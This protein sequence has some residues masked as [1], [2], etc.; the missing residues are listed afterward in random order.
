MEALSPTV[1]LLD[2]EGKSQRL[3]M[4][5]ACKLKLYVPKDARWQQKSEAIPIIKLIEEPYSPE[6]GRVLRSHTRK[7]KETEKKK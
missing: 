3:P 2:L 7:Q 4:V 6:L 5:H 1:Y